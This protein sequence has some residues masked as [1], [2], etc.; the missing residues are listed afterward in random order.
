MSLRIIPVRCLR[1]NYAYLI[2]ADEHRCVVV[3][4]SEAGPVIA[5]LRKHNLRLIAI[6]NTHHHYDHVGGN[7]A[8]CSRQEA[9]DGSPLEV[10]AHTSDRGRVPRQ[11]TFVADGTQFEA[12]GMRFSVMHVPGHTLGAIAYLVEDAVFT[13]DTL[14]VAGCGRMFEGT[15][16]QMHGSLMK[17]A[18]LPPTTRVYCGHEYTVAN[19]TFARLADPDNAAVKKRLAWAK[20]TT[21]GRKPTVPSTIADEIQTNPFLRCAEPAVRARYGNGAPAQV[22]AA[23][24]KAK[25]SF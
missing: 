1:D 7:D 17:F 20:T 12:A 21:A 13:G 16:V 8:L 3:D 22:F 5:G 19:L 6:L 9:G 10:I 23:V 15:P 18:A 11:T 4:P 2:T 24:R 14:F 25:D